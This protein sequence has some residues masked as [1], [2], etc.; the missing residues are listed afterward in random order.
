LHPDAE[1]ITLVSV[2]QQEGEENAELGSARLSTRLRGTSPPALV[3]RP[4]A[5]VM[6]AFGTLNWIIVLGYVV[7]NLGLGWAMS[8]KIH[9][10]EDYYM[11]D[12]TSPWWAL[13]ISVLATYVSALTFLGGPAW[14][15]GDGMA[16]LAIH[17]NYPLVIFIVVIFFLPF[18]FN[19]GVTSIYEY[20]ERRF[21][22]TSRLVMSGLFMITQSIASATIITATAIV[23]TFVTG[24]D[25]HWAIVGITLVVLGYTLMGGMNAVIWTDVLQGVVLFVGAGVILFYLLESTAPL[26]GALDMLAS[27][28]RLN[29][30][31]PALDFSIA[32]T[33]WAGVF[34]MT[35]FHVTVYGA[36]QMMVQRAL[37]AKN[38]GD[39]KKSYLM[40]GYAAFFIYFMFFFIGALL[41][42]YYKGRPFDQPNEIMLLYARALAV[43]GLMGIIVAAVVSASMST[44]SSAL[45]SLATVSIADF[46]KPLLR[47]DAR[48]GHYL[49][50]S[51]LL[52]A[53][54]ALLIIPM[55]FAFI[56]SKGSV[57]E[58]LTKVGSYFVG[59]KLAMFGLG[60]FSKHTTEKGL[61]VGVAAGFVGIFLLAVGLPFG[62]WTPPVIAWP[63]FVVIGGGVNIVVAVAA[64]LALTGRQREWHLDSVPGQQLRFAR[65]GLEVRDSSGWYLV[66]GR[67][68]AAVWGLPIL[69]VSIIGM[70]IA[71]GNL[72]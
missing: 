13:G 43:P 60:F 48:E 23:A 44:L 41:Y 28:G 50:A 68:D 4:R 20:L 70:L 54:W 46:Y 12:R 69:F 19:S 10:A 34:A 62:I 51:R 36:N 40:M 3:A 66:P 57:L 29:P 2:A 67:V 14:A 56:G 6:Q 53:F 64:S 58:E 65:E 26:S 31:N 71:F 59:A 38:I 39:A 52:T 27:N 15:Y 45:N 16:A 32:P 22:R 47:P 61:L 8:R 55:A 49:L 17:I 21:G 24:V 30:I 25:P 72:A 11:G 63:W 7:V 33:I 1:R 42:V 5:S 37:A 9:S 18:F 35:L